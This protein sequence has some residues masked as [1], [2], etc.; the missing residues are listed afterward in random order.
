[1]SYCV[2][3]P[4]ARLRTRRSGE[5][6]V[7]PTFYRLRDELRKPT[8]DP[9]GLCPKNMYRDYRPIVA[10]TR[11][12][13]HSICSAAPRSQASPNA[14]LRRAEGAGLDCE[15]ADRAI[16]GVATMRPMIGHCPQ[17]RVP[18]FTP[19]PVMLTH[20]RC[21]A[22]LRTRR[23]VIAANKGVLRWIAIPLATPVLAHLSRI[24]QTNGLPSRTNV[25]TRRK[26]TCGPQGVS[27]GLDPEQKLGVRETGCRPSRISATAAL[28]LQRIV[29]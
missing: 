23:P 27:P 24:A 11:R 20:L 25:C 6:A 15:S 14:A 26:R 16:I 29:N 4:R 13:G 1:V 22:A 5:R 28:R 12:H 7:T 10:R 8:L 17:S 21:A 2:A 19:N 3:D 18:V 9:V